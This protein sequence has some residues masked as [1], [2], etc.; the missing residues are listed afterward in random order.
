MATDTDDLND[1]TEHETVELLD[2]N[3]LDSENIPLYGA[4]LAGFLS[5]YLDFVT[6]NTVIGSASAAGTNYDVF[7][8]GIGCVLIGVTGIAVGRHL[9]T[10]TGSVGLILTGVASFIEVQ[11]RI[12]E[13][14]AEV[15]GTILSNAVSASVGIGIYVLI[16]TGALATIFT[17]GQFD[18]DWLSVE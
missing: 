6:V 12:N 16:G 7:Y 1:D 10:L 17:V 13:A 8:V 3:N 5:F 14:Q 18:L 9:L 11:S 4:F 15:A 2:P